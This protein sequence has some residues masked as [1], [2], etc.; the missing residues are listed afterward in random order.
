MLVMDEDN[1]QIASVAINLEKV[2]S[3]K[4]AVTARK[5]SDA[6]VSSDAGV[7]GCEDV[8]PS[9]PKVNGLTDSSEKV[10]PDDVMNKENDGESATFSIS[11][12]FISLFLILFYIDTSI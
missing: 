12:R 1:T 9:S 7:S 2:D 11:K 6:A 8:A 5:G 10:P 4:K 3:P